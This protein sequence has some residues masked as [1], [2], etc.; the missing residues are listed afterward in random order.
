MI[1]YGEKIKIAFVVEGYNGTFSTLHSQQNRVEVAITKRDTATGNAVALPCRITGK[2]YTSCDCSGTMEAVTGI[3][4]PLCVVPGDGYRL[5]LSLPENDA[6]AAQPAY[7][8]DFSVQVSNSTCAPGYTSDTG[9]EPG[10]MPCPV[11]TY[12]NAKSTECL[13]CPALFTTIDRAQASQDDCNVPF[14]N[15][16]QRF[17]AFSSTFMMLSNAGGSFLEQHDST[18][19]EE[20]VKLCDQDPG[21][22]AADAGNSEAI[23][24]KLYNHQE[25]NCFLS[26]DNEKTIKERDVR[27]VSQLILFRK[28]D[29]PEMRDVFFRRV[30]DFS[31][32]GSD[33]GGSYHNEHSP[34]A[35]A[36][37]CI[38]DVNCKAFDAGQ[39]RT[40]I[41]L[42]GS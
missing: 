14:V 9:R 21:C 5:R 22:K 28:I 25:N 40:R 39:S 32:R 12:Q 37:L 2:H 4:F 29:A 31:I 41:I 26:Y 15:A 35:C 24:A 7:S 27:T 8:D 34:E 36:Q 16:T 17:I 11:G 18:S 6:F 3:T 20:C 1:E 13:P 30:V 10:C 19:V 23:D 38:D 33:S 42:I